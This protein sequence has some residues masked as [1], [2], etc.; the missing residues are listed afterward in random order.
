MAEKEGSIIGQSNRR[1]ST[2][3]CVLTQS[4]PAGISNLV[5]DCAAQNVISFSEKVKG[6]GVIPCYFKAFTLQDMRDP[7]K[8]SLTPIVS[9]N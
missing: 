3:Q 1:L 7:N 5:S 6:N 9:K 8:F 4:D 2:V